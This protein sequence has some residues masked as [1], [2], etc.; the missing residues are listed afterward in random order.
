M[1]NFEVG[2]FTGRCC[3]FASFSYL[4]RTPQDGVQGAAGSNPVSPTTVPD[5]L[6]ANEGHPRGRLFRWDPR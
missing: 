6:K 5:T 3:A 2:E 1:L 4:N